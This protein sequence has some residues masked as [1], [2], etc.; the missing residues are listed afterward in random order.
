[1]FLVIGA[2][3]N[4]GS[5]VVK[6]LDAK[7]QKVRALVRD[8]KKAEGLKGKNVEIFQGD[9]TKSE[10]LEKALQGVDAAFVVLSSDEKLVETEKKVFAAAKKTG[11]KHLVKL[12]VA[13]ADAGS[14]IHFGKW[15]GES[16]KNLKESGLTHTILQPQ[17][18][19]QNL[20]GNLDSIK[21]EG[22]FYG[23]YKDGKAS[24]I[25][26]VD[27]ASTAAAILTSPA[28]HAG[29][30]YFLTGPQALSQK[31]LAEKLGKAIGKTITYVDIP[32]SAVVENLTKMGLPSW[33]AAD[34]GKLMD[35]VATGTAGT[36][37]KD[38]ETVTGRAPRNFDAFLSDN[39]GAFK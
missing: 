12:S 34:Y 29:K 22:K 8:T 38:V 37:S 31:D 9:A 10:S 28:K 6:Q 23:G 21:R 35:W 7:G 14:Q 17:M 1:M 3:G 15:H 26:V 27:I 2:T 24:M 20:F 33:L 4:I 25:D 5:Q 19:M 13:G 16:E 39:A 36:V 30:T 11:L 32:S 18:F